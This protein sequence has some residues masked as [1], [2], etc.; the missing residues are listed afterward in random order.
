MPCVTSTDF[1]TKLE[2]SFALHPW[3]GIYTSNHNFGMPSLKIKWVHA[4]V[5]PST[6]HGSRLTYKVES[7]MYFRSLS[8][9]L[10]MAFTSAWGPPW[11]CHLHQWCDRYGP[12]APTMGLVRVAKPQLLPVQHNVACK[13]HGSFWRHKFLILF[14]TMSTS[15]AV[16]YFENRTVFLPTDADGCE[17]MAQSSA[18]PTLQALPD[19]AIMP[20]MSRLN[21]NMSAIG[22]AAM[23]HCWCGTYMLRLRH[24]W[25]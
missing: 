5:L 24:D 14:T 3:I 22:E 17:Y 8:L 18:I 9:A 10:P 11:W 4:G 1:F 7:E 13:T 12:T 23:I 6:Q 19:E 16:L 2:N 21:I 25:K 15:S 20:P